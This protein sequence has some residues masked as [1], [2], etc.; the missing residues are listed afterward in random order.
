M[1]SIKMLSINIAIF[2]ISLCVLLVGLEIGLTFLQI[3]TKSNTRYIP[4]KGS[5]HVPGAYFRIS[6]EGFSEG[7]FNSH[8]FRDRERSYEKPANTYRILVLGDS[9]VEAVQVALEDSFTAILEKAL[10]AESCKT[11]FEVLS[12]GL[13]G[14]GTAEE[15]ERYMNFGID[16]SPDMVILA[17]T[18]ANDIQDNSKF[19]SW[20]M[21]RVYFNFD[22]KGNLVLDR[23]LVDAYDSGLTLPKRFFQALKRHSYLASLVSER[24]FLLK[25]LLSRARFEETHSS[26]ENAPGTKKLSEFSEL[27]IYLPDMSLR[28]REAYEITKALILK[29]KSA[30]EKNG[31]KFVLVTLTNAEQVHPEQG[32]EFSKQY[33]LKFDYDQPN[34]I[35]GELAK[36]EFITTLQLMPSFRKY[37]VE[38]GQ[39]LHGFG[40][41]TIGHWNER[42]HRLAAKEI[43]KFLTEKRL[44]P[45][46]SCASTNAGT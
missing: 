43:L 35:L 40:S 13:S 36:Q 28:W 30:V 23:S 42:G 4:N 41:G 12:F 15:Y 19:L 11:K 1:T 33:G 9:Q 25:Q 27:N 45:V 3:N 21:T 8:G 38:T 10:N 26:L 46:D 44:T 24:W 5:T 7:Y 32:E 34:R 20:E 22:A 2:V 17:V 37:H 39:Y 6:K 29:L 31:S 14:F 18:T 16:Y